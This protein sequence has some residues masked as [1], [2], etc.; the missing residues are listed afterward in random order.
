[1]AQSIIW[2][3][4]FVVLLALIPFGL[5]WI[6]RR[7]MGSSPG[8]ASA[9]KVVS[10]VAVGPQQRVVTVE[11]GPIGNRTWLVLG[12]TTQAVNCLHTISLESPLTKESVAKVGSDQG[13]V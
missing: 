8:N 10:A 3:V 5:K 12:V 9:C 13:A 1:M 11:V 7:A 4:G 6:Q 2:V